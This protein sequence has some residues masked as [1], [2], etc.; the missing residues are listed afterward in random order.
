VAK[1]INKK[2]PRHDIAKIL[3]KLALNTNQCT[4]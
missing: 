3:L 1:L 4:W 2:I